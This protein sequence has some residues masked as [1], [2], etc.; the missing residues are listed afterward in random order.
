MADIWEHLRGEPLP[1]QEADEEQEGEEDEEK[2]KPDAPTIKAQRIKVFMCAIQNHQLS[3]MS[4]DAEDAQDE[5]K[6]DLLGFVTSKD[7]YGVTPQ[8]IAT[9]H[10]RFHQ[11]AANRTDFVMQTKN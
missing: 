2:E 1:E 3:W 5:D 11:L 7:A 10:R 4:Q 6:K 8:D 9:I